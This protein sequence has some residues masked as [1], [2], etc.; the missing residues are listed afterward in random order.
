MLWLLIFV[1]AAAGGLSFA[2]PWNPVRRAMLLTAAATH[3]AMV[4]ACHWNAS[5]AAP[6]LNGWIAL[7]AA[8]FLFLAITSAVFLATACYA[9]GYL[10]REAGL[11]AA[12]DDPA[13]EVPFANFPEAIFT[14]CLLL[15][16]AAMTL[17]IL[18][19]HWGLLWV[20]VEATTLAS[21]P[22]IY[23]HRYARSLEATWK[24]L[25]ICSVGI[26]LALLGNFFLAMAARVGSD[27][28][29]HLVF[30]DLETHARQLDPRWLKAAFV[31]LLVGYGT[32]MGLAPMHTW[33]PDAHSEAPSLVSALLSG[34]LLNCA[35]L[36]ILRGH[37]LL[38]QAGLGQF[39]QDLLVLFGILSMSVAAM[40]VIGQL[41][42][43]RLLAYSSVEHMGILVLGVGIGGA[44]GFG[45]MLHAV[46]HSL[47]KAMLFLVAGNTLAHFHSK[48]TLHVRGT[49]SVLPVTGMLWVAGLLAITG[50]PPFGTFL[51]ELAVLKGLLDAE[52][53]W[54][55]AF[56]LTA[57]GIVFAGMSAVVVPLVYGRP[58]G[59]GVSP[60]EDR[61]GEADAAV[62][63]EG[64][65]HSADDS[66]ELSDATR[67]VRE[68][69]W[70]LL[71]PAL[72]GLAVLVLGLYVPP[73]LSDLLHRAASAVGA[74]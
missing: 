34:V 57:L 10:S 55:V 73:A 8:S 33:L 2:V 51:S 52:R 42:Y 66:G 12:D 31:L 48:S 41:D 26:A 43:K 71:P 58:G 30:S 32:K 36:A 69:W 29:L 7:D 27:G 23:Y 19:R 63:H 6:A 5:L 24:Y 39:S 13:V 11:S 20:A 74:E 4:A 46:N 22:L 56:Y 37:S 47:T 45:A 38:V 54:L 68:A 65:G 40:F 15:F 3:G 70:S 61:H 49:M 53:W 72:L 18:S 16:L 9:V 21:A 17:V 44:A 60:T 25:V 1:P 50:C 67:P 62:R 28:P 14:G 64:V 35:F 59:S